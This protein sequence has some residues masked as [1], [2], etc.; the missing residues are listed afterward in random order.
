MTKRR[1]FSAEFK[2]RVAPE[3]LVG[4]R[5]PAEPA[6]KHGVHPNMITVWS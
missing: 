1:R 5:R 2:A 4:E 3:D 6:G